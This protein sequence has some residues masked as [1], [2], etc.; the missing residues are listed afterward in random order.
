MR[1][2]PWILARSGRAW[3]LLTAHLPREKCC[4]P[5]F[6][7]TL[8]N[9]EHATESLRCVHIANAQWPVSCAEGSFAEVRVD[10]VAP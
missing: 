7:P 1:S 9:E 4:F 10:A 8:K 2:S 6:R 3:P 5:T